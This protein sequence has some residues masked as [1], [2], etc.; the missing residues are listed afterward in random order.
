MTNE[1]YYWYVQRRS[2]LNAYAAQASNMH[3]AA[4]AG[5][6]DGAT[7][8]PTPTPAPTPE[9]NTKEVTDETAFAAA[10]A[11][12]ETKTIELAGDISLSAES[13]GIKISDGQELSIDLGSSTLAATS[14]A[15]VS[16]GGNQDAVIVVQNGGKLTIGGNGSIV[17]SDA[18]Y[19]AP[20]KLTHKGDDSSKVAELVVAGGTYEGNTYVICGNGTRQNCKLTVT[21]GTFTANDAGTVEGSMA[22]YQPMS[23]DTVISGG[24]FTGTTAVVIKS[25]KCAIYG[26]KFVGNGIS[27]EFKHNTNGWYSTGG[28]LAVEVCDYPG[29]E[30]Q[31]SVFGGEFV[32][33]N[34][35]PIASY[36]QAGHERLT[37][38]VFGGTF[39]KQIDEE[40]VAD[41]FEQVETADGKW[42]V[43]KKA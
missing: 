29:G 11:D 3:A 32:S 8:T 9:P 14:L 38:F 10:L 26:G 15:K 21:G 19:M 2:L 39:S 12:P 5:S 4:A 7:P 40:L 42:T 13:N 23:C 30:A 35:A 20:L 41:G 27:A 33:E 36:A 37:H 43:Q 6:S 22:I 1:Q 34:A 18:D 28:A 17:G 25:G 24:T 31:L 16:A